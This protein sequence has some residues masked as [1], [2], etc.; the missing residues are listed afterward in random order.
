MTIGIEHVNDYPLIRLEIRIRI[1]ADSIRTEISNS[2]V[3][4]KYR[5]NVHRVCY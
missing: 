1:A 3:P 5:N 4:T 2:Q